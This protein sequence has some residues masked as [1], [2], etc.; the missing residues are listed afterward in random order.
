MV[1]NPV[2]CTYHDVVQDGVRVEVDDV[3]SDTDA[4]EEAPS[5]TTT[6]PPVE[7]SKPPLT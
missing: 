6:P 7:V 5:A 4:A 1:A 3:V 2:T